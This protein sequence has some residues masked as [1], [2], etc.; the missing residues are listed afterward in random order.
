MVY[1]PDKPGKQDVSR[2]L[3]ITLIY[4]LLVF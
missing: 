1:E 3:L 2:Y 4:W